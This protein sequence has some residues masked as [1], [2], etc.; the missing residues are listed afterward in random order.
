MKTPPD[1][2]P[3]RWM[4]ALPPISDRFFVVT[5]MVGLVV[6]GITIGQMLCLRGRDH[7][8]QTQLSAVHERLQILERLR[9]IEDRLKVLEQG[10]P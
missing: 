9:S 8:G 7:E 10:R 5:F 4:Q 3:R 6:L 2:W 1:A